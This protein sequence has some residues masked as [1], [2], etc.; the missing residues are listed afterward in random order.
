[1]MSARG[2][3]TRWILSVWFG[4]TPVSRAVAALLGP[5]SLLT[6]WHSVRARR[7][8]ER[9]PSPRTSVLVVGNLLAGGTG[10]TPLVIALAKAI[11]AS[12][13]RV[14]LLCSGYGARRSDARQVRAGD[15]AGEHGDEAV[16]LATESGLPV[17]AGRRRDRALECLL[18]A[19]P[20]I[21]LVISDDGLQHRHLPRTL[22]LVVFDSRGLGNGRLLPAGPLREALPADRNLGAIAVNDSPPPPGVNAR[23]VFQFR[24]QPT[25]LSR[26]GDGQ[27]LSP[28]AFQARHRGRAICALAAIGAPERF[29][30]LLGQ[31]GIAPTRTLALADHAPISADLLAEIPEPLVVMTAKDAVKCR[32]FADDRCWV[33]HIEAQPDPQLLI[34]LQ[35]ALLGNKTA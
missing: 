7:A 33:L 1:M 16:L 26:I 35:G 30:T 34:W 29:F 19:H 8:I 32:R 17:A 23:Q 28:E 11:S 22:E 5:L 2:M 3:L 6:H 31:L 25:G 15:D 12:G 21:D 18:A 4:Q 9:L 10:K 27:W 24:I 20:E 13:V 14:G